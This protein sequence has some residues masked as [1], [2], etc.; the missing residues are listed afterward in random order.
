M[1]RNQLENYMVVP[2]QDRRSRSREVKTEEETKWG[3]EGG[4]VS[5][6][7]SS[8]LSIGRCPFITL[9]LGEPHREIYYFHGAKRNGFRGVRNRCP[10]S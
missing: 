9:F 1:G 2:K 5:V 7:V 10:L 6:R 4:S 3:R 8:V